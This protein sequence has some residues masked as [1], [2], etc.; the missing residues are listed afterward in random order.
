[1]N[2]YQIVG[3]IVL[4]FAGALPILASG[5]S[6]AGEARVRPVAESARPR[7]VAVAPVVDEAARRTLHFSGI[8]RAERRA[9]LSYTIAGRLESR[10]V[11]VGDRVREG[12][13]LARLDFQ[14]FRN[15]EQA[16]AAR[17]RDARARL[18]QLERDDARVSRLLETRAVVAEEVEKVR[19]GQES[20]AAAVDGAIAQ[21]AETRRM[22]AETR[23]IAPFAGTV[24]AVL[25]Q[26]GEYARPGAPVVIVSGE[27]RLEVE[28]EV[29]ESER[30]WL[31][32][33]ATVSVTL[34]LADTRERRI[35]DVEVDPDRA[36][37]A[38]H[39]RDAVQ[40]SIR[41]IGRATRGAGR[42]F[43]VIIALDD[44]GDRVAPGLT[45]D[46]AI[47]TPPRSA[48]LVPL[49][50]IVDPGGKDP[51]VYRVTSALVGAG[52]GEPWA[53]RVPLEIVELIG[54][55]VSVRG[56]ALAA[57]DRVVIDGHAGLIAGETVEVRR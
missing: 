4:L 35:D 24:S 45:A 21:L 19:A 34:P 8:V 56:A 20:A 53:E 50:A 17:L 27:E 3:P 5:C 16:A 28:I 1:M 32:E 22:V 30:A 25:M 37:H 43:P 46:I 39:V 23:L 6:S 41:S 11:E 38:G 14:Q 51:F 48:T 57:G 10:A 2:K 13:V 12:Q 44:P 18:A 52:A 9:Q 29:P 47:T 54:E 33:G 31:H 49:A 15:A 42:L 36:S 26:P 40:G 7:P 55:S